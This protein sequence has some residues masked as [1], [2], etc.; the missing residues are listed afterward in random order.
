MCWFAFCLAKITKTGSSYAIEEVG[1]K[2]TLDLAN[3]VGTWTGADMWGPTEIT[4]T[5][6]AEGKLEITGVGVTFMTGAWGEVIIDQQTVV[7]DIDGTTGAFTISEQYYMTTTYDDGSGGG[8][9]EQAPYALSG[10]GTI[11]P[12]TNVMDLVYDFVQ[13]GT[14]YTEWLTP[15]G[16]NFHEINTL[17]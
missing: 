2:S 10:T 8:A 16:Y 17:N 5:L 12:C 13:D 9:V 15:F 3:Y 6:N 1:E 11:D 14:S 4:T 7:M